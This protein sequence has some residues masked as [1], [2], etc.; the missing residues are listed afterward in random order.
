MIFFNTVISTT[1][2]AIIFCKLKY[3]FQ[4]KISYVGASDCLMHTG[5]FTPSN[6]AYS[7][8]MHRMLGIIYQK[9]SVTNLMFI[10]PCIVIYFC[11]KTN[12]MDNISNL[13]YFVVTLYIFRTVF[14]ECSISSPLASR[15]QNLFDIY[16]MLYVQS[17]M[18]DDGRK[19]CPK[20]V[21]CYY[22]IK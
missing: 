22:K 7:C 16:L 20:H 19:D 13:L 6:I 15:Q 4:C 17:S 2:R 5:I 9:S 8:Y 3:R 11:S 18:P 21:E 12:E 1:K 10:R 14:P